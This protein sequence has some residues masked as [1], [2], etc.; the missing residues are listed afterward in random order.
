MLEERLPNDANS[1]P[2]AASALASRSRSLLAPN[3]S[4]RS[5]SSCSGAAASSADACAFSSAKRSVSSA[6]SSCT[7]AA[8]SRSFALRATSWCSSRAMLRSI[9][10]KLW[11]AT[12]SRCTAARCT[13]S[14]WTSFRASRDCVCTSR[15]ASWAELTS[16]RSRS[17]F[18]SI[19]RR[20]LGRAADS[21][22]VFSCVACA[23]LS[24]VFSPGRGASVSICW[25][26]SSSRSYAWRRSSCV[27]TASSATWNVPGTS[28]M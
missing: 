2:T 4:S 3:H 28:S 17:C 13:A 18:A 14:C 9:S 5:R 27:A 19:A 26:T 24:L 8:S 1:A 23:S 22:A 15:A 25:C 20:T 16:I 6:P 12:C 10:P 11:P 21:A 7:R